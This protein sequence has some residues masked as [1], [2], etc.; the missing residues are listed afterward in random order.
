[1]NIKIWDKAKQG[2]LLILLGAVFSVV[3]FYYNTNA[4]T[5]QSQK[6]NIQQQTEIKETQTRVEKLEL[7]GAVNATEIKQIKASLDRIEKKIDRL[8]EENNH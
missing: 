7:D 2:I 1:M 4:M 8:I 3:P 6:V 5:E